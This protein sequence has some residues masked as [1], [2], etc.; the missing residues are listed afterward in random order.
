MDPLRLALRALFVYMF[1][2]A[3]VRSSG[4]RTLRQTD[5]VSFVLALIIGDMFDDAFWAEGPFAEF[6]IGAGTLVLVHVLMK[7]FVA[8]GDRDRERRDS[9][10]AGS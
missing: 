10:R 3:L 9:L 1:T 7:A 2:L 4:A 5:V 8:S 6:V